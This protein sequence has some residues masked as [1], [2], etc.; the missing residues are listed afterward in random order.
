MTGEPVIIRNLLEGNSL[1]LPSF[2]VQHG[3]VSTVDVVIP[4]FEGSLTASSRSI[5]HPNINMTFTTSIS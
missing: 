2:Y 4:G 1:D 5:V 3:I